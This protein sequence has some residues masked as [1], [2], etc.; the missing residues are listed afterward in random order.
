MN[1]YQYIWVFYSEF[2]FIHVIV[3]FIW[4]RIESNFTSGSLDSKSIG[5]ATW[6]TP[7]HSLMASSKLPC[8]LRSAFHSVSRSFA[9][10]RSSNGFVLFWFAAKSSS[11]INNTH[12]SYLFNYH[13]I[14]SFLGNYFMVENHQKDLFYYNVCKDSALLIGIICVQSGYSLPV[15]FVMKYI[16][17]IYILKES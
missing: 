17:F 1:W 13:H 14:L 8:S 7:V 16:F 11:Q 5:V 12:L 3:N 2:C 9:P 4:T 10:G 6:N 15:D